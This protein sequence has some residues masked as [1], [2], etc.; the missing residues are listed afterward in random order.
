VLDIQPSPAKIAGKRPSKL[1]RITKKP[2]LLLQPPKRE[3]V[4]TECESIDNQTLYKPRV[5][6]GS[7]LMTKGLEFDA[8]IL[9]NASRKHYPISDV[10]GVNP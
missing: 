5:V 6:I 8:V 2:G 3:S 7:I 9:V 10:D 4:I 1:V